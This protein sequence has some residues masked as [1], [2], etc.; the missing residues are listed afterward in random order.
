VIGLPDIHPVTI[1]REGIG[2]Q[3][4]NQIV[5]AFLAKAGATVKKQCARKVSYPAE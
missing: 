5:S 2:R 1:G 3:G 4:G